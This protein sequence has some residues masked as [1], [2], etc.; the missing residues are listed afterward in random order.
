MHR[1]TAA[2]LLLFSLA[3]RAETYTEAQRPRVTPVVETVRQNRAAVVNIAATQIV[4]VRDHGFG[5]I[6]LF[7]LFDTPYS[8]QM[9]T[10]SVGSGAVIH[11]SGYVLTNAHVVAQASELKVIFADKTELPAEVVASMAE[12]DLAIIKVDTG[13][14]R[15]PSVRL[16][17][18]DDLMVGETVI[19][20]GNPVG[21]QHTVT[22]GIVSALERTLEI[23]PG[24][25]FR[26]IV[27]TD[28]AI[29]PGNSGGPLLNLVGEVIGV[30]TAIRSDAQNVGFAIAI[31]RVKAMLPELLGV[32]SRSRVRLGLTWDIREIDGGVR[33]AQVEPGSPAQKAG[34][35][36]GMIVSSIDGNPAAGLVDVLVGT[37]EQQVGRAFPL[38]VKDGDRMREVRVAIEALPRPDGGAL[39]L[40]RFG[41]QVQELDAQ[42]ALRLGIRAGGALAVQQVVR[43]SPAEQAGLLQGDVI[44]QVGRFGVR[45]LDTLGLLL[46]RVSS[47]DRVPVRVVRVRGRSMYSTSILLRAR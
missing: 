13:G 46:E 7:D 25:S 15:L 17:R 43:G 21:L 36:A 34:L 11:P 5:G 32:E 8:R 31:D 41:M 19:A 29:N 33:V 22:T 10:N 4:T 37:L 45:D 1:L 24:V 39:A 28:A 3:A 6:P 12:E 30:N 27:Q 47:G 18:S 40:K 42:L 9:K 44:T 23:R 2:I 20:I 16:G 35:S 26:D 38:T 14:K